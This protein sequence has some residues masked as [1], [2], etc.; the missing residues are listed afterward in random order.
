MTAVRTRFL[1]SRAAA[2]HMIPQGSG[3]IPFFGG[4]GDPVPDY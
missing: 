4:Y 2:R 3:V 1:T